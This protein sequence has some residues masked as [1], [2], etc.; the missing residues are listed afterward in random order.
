MLDNRHVSL[1]SIHS[2][3]ILFY[4]IIFFLAVYEIGNPTDL[5]FVDF[6]NKDDDN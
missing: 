3:K 1:H 2:K 6:N 4:Y 5:F